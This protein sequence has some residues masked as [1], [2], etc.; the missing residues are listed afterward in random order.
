MRQSCYP[1]T[2]GLPLPSE[3][4]GQESQWRRWSIAHHLFFPPSLVTEGALPTPLKQPLL[5]Y[6][7]LVIHHQKVRSRKQ[8]RPR[9]FGPEIPAFWVPR[10]RGCGLQRTC[11]LHPWDSSPHRK[12]CNQ[13]RVRV[14]PSTGVPVTKSKYG[15]NTY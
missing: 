4:L 14:G 5:G 9:L 3:G 11:P 6:P 1:C 8:A 13:R 2:P 12:G 10:A 7:H 15:V